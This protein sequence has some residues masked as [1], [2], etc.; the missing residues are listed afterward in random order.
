MMGQP[1]NLPFAPP[2]TVRCCST[3]CCT[4]LTSA[5]QPDP[6]TSQ[7][8]KLWAGDA[9]AL[10]LS[11]HEARRKGVGG[12]ALLLWLPHTHTCIGCTP[13]GMA[14]I[15][16]QSLSC[17]VC[18][19]GQIACWPSSSPRAT[20]SAGQDWLYRPCA[21]ATPRAGRGARLTLLSLWWPRCSPW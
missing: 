19:D 12:H 8:S 2:R 9:T 21:T 14:V 4:A 11:P 18:A 16:T 17:G 13:P 6:P 10:P 15:I 1:P 20:G 7:K 3:C 5:T